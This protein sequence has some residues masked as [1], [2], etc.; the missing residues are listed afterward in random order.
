M[1]I[2]VWNCSPNFN[3]LSI[4]ISSLVSLHFCGAGFSSRHVSLGLDVRCWENTPPFCLSCTVPQWWQVIVRAQKLWSGLVTAE[5]EQGTVAVPS[6]G[7]AGRGASHTCVTAASP[8]SWDSDAAGADGA[9]REPV[10]EN[11]QASQL[12]RPVLP[13]WRGA[14]ASPRLPLPT[15]QNC[16]CR[17]PVLGQPDFTLSHCCLL[18][19]GR[20]WSST[21]PGLV[22]PLVSGTFSRVCVVIFVIV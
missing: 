16:C 4:H 21:P 14:G 10:A 15:Q 18:N 20:C 12:P 3:F 7:L 5:L 22:R 13:L 6:W 19:F 11:V 1:T 8:C 9:G 2:S 17:S